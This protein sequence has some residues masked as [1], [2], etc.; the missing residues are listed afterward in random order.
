MDPV[1]AFSLAGTILQFIDSGTRFVGLAWGLY[2]SGSNDTSTYGDVLKITKDLDAILPQLKSTESHS[3]A[4]KSI[5]QL[6]A[7]CGTTTT[8]FLAIL[9]AAGAAGSARKRDAMKT[10]F[11]LTCKKDEIKSF[12][13]QLSSFRNQL[14]LHLL[15]SLR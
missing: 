9:H 1:V 15:L 2:S 8:R 13:D 6:A 10:A 3:D 4:E 14:N 11:R 12:Q 7:D 5:S